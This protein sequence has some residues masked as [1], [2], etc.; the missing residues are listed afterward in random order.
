MKIHIYKWPMDKIPLN[1]VPFYKDDTAEDI[2]KTE[3]LYKKWTLKASERFNI[4]TFDEATMDSADDE[5][6][7][8]AMLSIYND[9]IANEIRNYIKNDKVFIVNSDRERDWRLCLLCR[10]CDDKKRLIV[11]SVLWMWMWTFAETY[12]GFLKLLN[13]KFKEMW[14]EEVGYH[15]PVARCLKPDL[16]KEDYDRVLRLWATD[17]YMWTRCYIKYL[18]KKK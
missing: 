3:A 17:D 7:R 11:D 8:E 18:N 10:E 2:K 13:N 9:D 6:K 16:S 5:D 1:A 14:Y 15:F 4:E 12:R